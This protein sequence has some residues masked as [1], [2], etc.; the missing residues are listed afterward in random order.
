MPM[1]KVWSSLPLFLVNSQPAIFLCR[2]SPKSGNE[3]GIELR[4]F[5]EIHDYLVQVRDNRLY[6]TISKIGTEMWKMGQKFIQELKLSMTCRVPI[7][8]KVSQRKKT[9]GDF[10]TEFNINGAKNL[11]IAVTH[12]FR[13]LSKLWLSLRPFSQKAR[14]LHNLKKNHI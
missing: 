14:L 2:T 13:T 7:F 6:R 10:D 9:F 1:R 12:L 11:G 3:R 5:H 4:Q 8:R